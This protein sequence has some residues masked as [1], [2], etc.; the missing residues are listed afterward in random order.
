MHVE[1]V[2]GTGEDSTVPCV[3]TSCAEM[4]IASVL[5]RISTDE[6]HWA[7]C[8]AGERQGLM[9][10]R[11]QAK[12]I[13]TTRGC[14]MLTQTTRY[15]K[16]RVPGRDCWVHGGCWLH[17]ALLVHAGAASAVLSSS[18]CCTVSSSGQAHVQG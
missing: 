3:H 16:D 9:H 12:P 14:H 8:A 11:P 13:H 2:M 10:D 4:R 15:Q 1:A 7:S 18:G 17:R 5:K 6:P